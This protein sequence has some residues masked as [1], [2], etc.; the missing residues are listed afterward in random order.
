MTLRDP[1]AQQR[2]EAE[3]Y[4]EANVGA[5]TVLTAHEPGLL[6]TYEDLPSA[7]KEAW[8]VIE[9]GESPIRSKGII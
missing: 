3:K 7:V 8:L 2:T 1:S 5:Y 9:A 4:F 6:S